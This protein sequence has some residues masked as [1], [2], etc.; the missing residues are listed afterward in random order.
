M[1]GLACSVL[2]LLLAGGIEIGEELSLP[3]DASGTGIQATPAAA[4]GGGV[5]LVVWREGW[6]GKGGSAR[7]RA[8]RVS[9]DGKLLDRQSSEIAPAPAGVQERPR[10]AFGGG[11]FLVV[12]QDFRNGKDYDILAARITLE[13]R[14]LDREPIAVAAGPRNQ[15]L[16]DVAS[17]GKSFLVVWQGLAGDETA[18]RGFAAAVSAGGKTG[19]PIETGMTPQPRV[20]WNGARYLAASGGAGFWSGSVQVVALSADGA[21]QGKPVLAIRGTKAAVFSLSAA[22]DNGWLLASH[23]SLPDPWGWGGPG[24]MRAVR[25]GEDGKPVNQD[26]I[27]EPAGVQDRLPGWLDLGRKKEAGATWPWGESASAFDGTHSVVVW[28]RHHLSG[29][30]MTDLVDCDLIAARVDGFTSLDPAGV[31]AAA[32]QAEERHPALASDGRGRTLLVHEK[33]GTNGR[34]A[35]VGRML[36]QPLPP[37]ATLWRP[38]FGLDRVGHGAES[39]AF[40]ADAIARPDRIIHPV[41]LGTILVPSDWLILADGQGGEIEVAAICRTGDLPEA[42]A[43]AWFASAAEEKT[44]VALA[45]VRDR[46]VRAR[47]PLPPAP[48]GVD[49]DVL[50][51]S[52]DRAGGDR[53]WHKEIP[54][55]LIRRPPQWPAFGATETTLRYDAPISVRADDGTFSSLSYDEAWDPGLR[56]VVVALP[57]GSRFVFWRGSSYVPFWAGRFNTGLSYEWAET[58]PPPDGF[59]DCVEPLM[60]KELR[61]G[62]VR[63]L[64]S[65]PARIRV[66]WSYQSCDFKYKVWGDSAVEDYTF[67]PDGFGTRVLTLQSAPGADYELSEF[68]ILTPQSTYPFSVLPPDLVDIIFLDGEKREISFPFLAAEQGDKMKSR[69]IPAIYRVRMHKDDPAAA[70]YFN[71]LDTRLPPTVFGPFADEGEIVTPCYWGSHWPLARGKTTGSTIDDRVRFTPCH[72]SV[73]SWARSRPAPVRTA[74]LETL[75]T[76]GR[77]KTM[78]VET[79]VWLIGTS[80][81]DDARLLEWA[82]S[83]ASAPA[84]EVRGARLEAETCVPERRAIRLVVEGPVVIIDLEPRAVCVNPVFELDAAPGTLAR[85]EL[86]GRR[87][88]AKDYAWDGRTLWIDATLKE[89]SQVRLVFSG[90]TRS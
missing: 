2:S 68:I 46:V 9:P 54:A 60:D 67:Y 47:L 41:D 65:T 12:W 33:G 27:K 53:R 38:P 44:A 77:P 57:N 85:V 69:D 36:S 15:V 24:A 70:I 55:M 43:A 40:E 37:R 6:H 79:W 73:M 29:E 17:D 20:A 18:Y 62:R 88:D 58:S 13:G 25:I 7:I 30:K 48:A 63:I 21:P 76:L 87:L 34:G 45:L 56:D 16:P 28:Q 51:V 49:R 39:A 42:R 84:V 81:A 22:A 5:Y 82:R 71:P 75:D 50:H 89:A 14:V 64:E 31:P 66:R 74:R 23:R 35:V 1:S 83:F 11:A 3:A 61:Y 86:G 80:A 52:I 4:F 26:G 8:A 59:T 72:N 78:V 90:E 10:V 32:T 19:R